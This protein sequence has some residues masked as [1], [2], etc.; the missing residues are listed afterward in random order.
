MYSTCMP[1]KEAHALRGRP[2]A[3]AAIPR[4]IG[5]RRRRRSPPTLSHHLAETVFIAETVCGSAASQ[6]RDAQGTLVAEIALNR[7]SGGAGDAGGG[8]RRDH[9]HR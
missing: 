8:D 4:R 3:G 2:P 1:H 5:H 6:G 9:R 7:H